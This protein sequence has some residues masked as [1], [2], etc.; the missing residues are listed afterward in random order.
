MTV[1]DL[2]AMAY[3]AAETVVTFEAGSGIMERQMMPLAMQL[4]GVVVLEQPLV[5]AIVLI[6]FVVVERPF[7]AVGMVVV[8]AAAVISAAAAAATQLI[9]MREN[10]REV[11]CFESFVLDRT[12]HQTARDLRVVAEITVVL[13]D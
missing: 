6:G 10:L 1:V 5:V 3:L 12:C 9:G 13:W 11:K 4:L 7:A 2:V 8:A